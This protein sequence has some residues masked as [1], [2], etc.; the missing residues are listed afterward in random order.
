MHPTIPFDPTLDLTFSRLVPVKKDAMWRA[1]TEPERLMQWF[2]PLPWK[3]I[4]CEIDLRPSGKF[5]TTMLSPDGQHISNV[6]CY[7]EVVP[8]QK[9]VW[10]NAVL[11]GFRPKTESSESSLPN[12]GFTFTAVIEFEDKGQDTHYK[13]TV[14]HA[15]VENCKKH[16][17]MGFEIGWGIALDQMIQMIQKSS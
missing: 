6:G 3:T 12:P 10:T 16:A 1:W 15:D 14:L 8:H 2:C 11:P 5:E 7:L 4:Q 9:L 13:A 17:D